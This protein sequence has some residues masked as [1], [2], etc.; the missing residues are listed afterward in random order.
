MTAPVM[1]TIAPMRVD[2]TAPVTQAAV[3]GGMRMQFVL[4]KGGDAGDS[5]RAHRRARAPSG[6]HCAD[7]AAWG[8]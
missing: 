3:A 7:A 5:A 8:G 1:H 4:P 2:M 6:W